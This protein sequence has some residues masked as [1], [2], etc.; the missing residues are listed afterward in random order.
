MDSSLQVIEVGETFSLTISEAGK[1]FAWGT[2]DFFE[3]GKQNIQNDEFEENSIVCLPFE[4]GIRPK[5]VKTLF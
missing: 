3:L 2:N 4:S 5:K 1:V